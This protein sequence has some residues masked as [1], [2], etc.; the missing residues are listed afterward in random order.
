[1]KKTILLF[2]LLFCIT[3]SYAQGFYSLARHVDSVYANDTG[4]DGPKTNI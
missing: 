1:M 4:E 2:T 3:K